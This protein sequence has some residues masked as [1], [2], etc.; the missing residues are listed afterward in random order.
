[1][2]SFRREVMG[3]GI[4][5][6]ILSTFFL[7]AYF[8]YGKKLEKIVNIN[9]GN[10]TP[11]HT[12]N[13]GVDYVPT[14]R[15]ILL[16]HHF[17][18]IAGAGPIVGPVLAAQFGWLPAFLWILF[19][20]IFIGG[21]HDFTTLIASVRH[22][23]K[24]IGTIIEETI[25]KRGK[26][27]FL[28]FAIS[29]LVLLI[30]AFSIIIAHTFVKYPQAATAS[31]IFIGI[32]MLFGF[33]NRN[34]KIPFFLLSL[35]SIILLLAGIHLGILFPIKLSVNTWMVI[36]FIYIYIASV[37]PVWA[38]LQPRDYLNSFLLYGIMILGIIGILY[39]NPTLK[40]PAFSSYHQKI[41]DMFPI[42]FITIACGAISGF[43][44]LVSSG[45]TSKQLDSEKDSKLIGYGGMLIEGVLALIA[46]I[47]ATY[48][49]KGSYFKLLGP[50]GNDA[51]GV[52]SNGLGF[53]MSK[54][55]IPLESAVIFS[56]LAI[57]AFALTTLDTSS[58]LCR[59]AFQELF[60]DT[61][62]KKVE[63]FIVKNRYIATFIMLLIAGI[64]ASG[65][66]VLKIWPMFG[67]ANQLLAAISLLAVVLWL[68]KKKRTFLFALI[69][70]LFMFLITISSLLNIGILNLE[71]LNSQDKMTVIIRIA[72]TLF[73]LFVAF[74][75]IFLSFS[76]IKREKKS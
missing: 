52:F 50:N 12:L 56:A 16:G 8:I 75:L 10:P 65:K 72:V 61:K 36:L 23:G 4:L 26:V 58:R 46:L 14:K 76:A 29:T 51:I 47:T 30:S 9:K 64:M 48:L 6:L 41:G 60:E 1:L 32:A 63:K 17:A 37:T 57:S 31:V 67:S 24:S 40:Y 3:A 49:S 5:I 44:S 25:G 15:E 69:P 22:R 38:L 28:I 34:S 27:L 7:I 18:S 45:T 13:D 43:H 11:S 53:F 33:L 55:G 39:L 71:S 73:L 70:M 74:S 68:I 42:L 66:E 35:T 19:G 21:V 62:N 20:A 2:K 54:L 59:F